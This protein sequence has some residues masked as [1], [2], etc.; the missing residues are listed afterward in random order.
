LRAVIV[1]N[2]VLRKRPNRLEALKTSV[3]RRRLLIGGGIGAG[4]LLAW[5][6]WPRDY[7]VTVMPGD[8]EHV[9]NSFLKIGEDGRI[10]AVIPQIEMGQGSFTQLAQILADELGADWRTIAVEPAP[11]NPVYTNALLAADWSEGIATQVFGEPA[12]WVKQRLAQAASFQA[13]GGSTSLRAFG[14][15]VREAA[16]AAQTLLCM[17]A[18]ARWDVDWRACDTAGGFVVLGKERLRFGELAADASKFT[19][20]TPLPYR[21]GE[22]DRLRGESLPRLDLPAKVDGSLN[23]AADVRLPDMVYASVRMG[24]LGDT[25]YKGIDRKALSKQPGIL[26]LVENSFW[27]AAVAKTWWAANQ[28]LDRAKPQFETSGA[29]PESKSAYGA[30]AAALKVEG[31]GYL[32]HGDA[33][34]AL[35]TGKVIRA[36][37]HADFAPHLALEPMAATAALRDGKLELWI[38]TQVPQLARKTAAKA[39]GFAEDDV[40]IHPMMIGGSFGRKYETEI[41]AQAAIIASEIGRPVQLSWSRAQDV[42]ADRMRPAASAK[43]TAQIEPDG[44]IH[45]WQANIA[46]PATMTELQARILN[47]QRPADAQRDAAGKVDVHTLSGAVPPYAIPNLN[48]VHHPV[49]L[50]IATGKWRSGADSFTAFFNEC[51]IDELAKASGV[52]AFSFRMAMMGENPR[53]AACLTRVASLANWQ[54]GGAGTQQG[55]ACHAMLGSSIAVIAEASVSELQRIT[56]T[57]LIAVADVGRK[58]NPEI[59]I[60]QIEGGLL[61]GMAAAI[62]NRVV[63]EKGMVAPTRLGGYN[64]PV[65][66][67]APTIIVELIG[68]KEPY[69]GI[70]ELAVPPV[71][72]A[73]ANALFAGSGRRFRTLPLLPG[74]NP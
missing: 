17:A 50:G 64:L 74:M 13:T 43:L 68:S 58:V 40:I 8:D 5:S 42:Q 69:G 35:A 62:S 27:V 57:K 61:F 19:P 65:L 53:M 24:P 10:T 44:R 46:A 73:L 66:A 55:L 11:I 15:L 34:S 26:H 28:A 47:G 38:A 1:P 18:A 29:L 25:R 12:R 21:T 2:A 51:F 16:A 67:Q 31:N 48:I 70:G 20:P 7:V 33:P 14:P 39:I 6:V 4:L 9:F 3:D 45:A 23:Y 56:V 37:Y 36:D 71:A 63:I 49:D 30:L 41:A 59:A 60:Q 22:K 52:E 72:P 54:G 32:A